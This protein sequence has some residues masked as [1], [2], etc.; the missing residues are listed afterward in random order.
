M[1]PYHVLYLQQLQ[2][3]LFLRHTC[4]VK[5]HHESDPLSA[6]G[7]LLSLMNFLIIIAY[8]RNVVTN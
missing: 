7:S 1:G 8:S 6:N 5:R 3:F 4:D 2:Y